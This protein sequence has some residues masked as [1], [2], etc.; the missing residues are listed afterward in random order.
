MRVKVAGQTK[1]YK[2]GIC[3]FSA[4]PSIKERE[5]RW[6]ARNKDIVSKWSDTSTSR[7]LFQSASNI[8]IQLSVFV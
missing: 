1:G 6:L 4:A 5:Q 7:L 2:T 3:L 8:K